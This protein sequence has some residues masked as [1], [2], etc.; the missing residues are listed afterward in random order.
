MPDDRGRFS[1]V[2]RSAYK[3]PPCP[4]C[5]GRTVQ[6]WVDAS[7]LAD[8]PGEVWS[9]PGSYRCADTACVG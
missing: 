3:P 6:Q 9:I 1:D 4:K 2:E 8:A 5:G 7:D